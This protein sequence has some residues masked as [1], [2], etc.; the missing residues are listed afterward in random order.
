MK[1]YGYIPAKIDATHW[2]FGASTAPKDLLQLDRNWQPYLPKYEPQ[3]VNFET[4]GCGVFG[5]LNAVEILM[6]KI[7]GNDFNYAE[8]YQYNLVGINPPIGS[9]PHVVAETI[10]KNGVILEEILPMTQTLEEYKTPRPVPEYYVSHGQKWLSEHSFYHEWVFTNSPSKEARIALIREALQYSPLALSVTAWY[11]EVN[12][13]YPD[14]GQPNSHWVTCFAMDGDSP[15]IFDSYAQDG[16]PIKK[17]SP[18]H[19]IEMCKRY[20]I[21][22][23]ETPVEKENWIQGMLKSI[24]QALGIVREEIKTVTMTPINN[25]PKIDS[26]PIVNKTNGE[27]L[28]DIALPLKGQY[29]TLDATVPKAFNCAECMSYLLKQ[30]GYT[31]PEKGFQGT[32]AIDAWLQKNATLTN[33]P[34]FGDIIISVTQGSDHGHIGQI[35]HE[36]ILSNDSQT[37]TLESYWTVTGWLNFY[38]NSKKLVTKFYRL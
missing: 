27:K 28:Y 6:K 36:A 31:I 20:Y 17:L 23:G 1:N 34:S 33:Q 32:V 2:M 19:H 21:G 22:V 35:G 7:F 11:P 5:T 9:D 4:F 26:Q 25:Q 15:L 10:R 13:M 18:D 3:A 38:K 24:L 16:N 8:R 30:A 29:L 12:G 37:G 14:N